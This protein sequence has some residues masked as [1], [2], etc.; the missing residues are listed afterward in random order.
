MTLRDK[1]TVRRDFLGCESLS[2]SE[3][4]GEEQWRGKLE[5]LRKNEAVHEVCLCE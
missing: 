3:D 2:M 1:Q 4:A 5:S